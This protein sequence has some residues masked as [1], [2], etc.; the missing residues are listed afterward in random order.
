MTHFGLVF[1]TWRDFGKDFRVRA[2]PTQEWKYTDIYSASFCIFYNLLFSTEETGNGW[3]CSVL[4]HKLCCNTKGFCIWAITEQKQTAKKTAQKLQNN[5]LPF[6]CDACVAQCH[7]ISSITS[8]AQGD[9]LGELPSKTVSEEH[10]CI[11]SLPALS[12]RNVDC[13]YSIT[14]EKNPICVLLYSLSRKHCECILSGYSLY[15]SM[16]F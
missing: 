16:V 9:L 14:I 5:S 6:Y 10:V 13:Y 11:Y 2:T 7:K 1:S 12:R 15:I 4:P 8:A 3:I